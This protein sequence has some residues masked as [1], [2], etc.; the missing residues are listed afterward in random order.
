[1][2]WM[3]ATGSTVISQVLDSFVVSYLAFSLGKSLTGQVPATLPEV[4]SIATTGKKRKRFYCLSNY[5]S[6]CFLLWLQLWCQFW[7]QFLYVCKLLFPIFNSML[8]FVLFV[9]TI[10][11]CLVFTLQ[12]IAH[13]HWLVPAVSSLFYFTFLRFT[14]YLH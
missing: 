12:S 10:N 1:M 5:L 14:S 8:N 9:M 7:F 6:Y 4:L 3:R 11:E 13:T 2:L